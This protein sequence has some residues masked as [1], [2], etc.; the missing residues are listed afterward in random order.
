[1]AG[2]EGAKGKGKSLIAMEGEMAFELEF[3]RRNIHCSKGSKM[4]RAIEKPTVFQKKGIFYNWNVL[5]WQE[6]N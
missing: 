1:M 6:W 5:G 4:S 2:M 3:C